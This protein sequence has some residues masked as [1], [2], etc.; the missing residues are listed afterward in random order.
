MILLSR[1]LRLAGVSLL[2]AL[3]LQSCKTAVPEL[4]DTEGSPLSQS[5]PA[6]YRLAVAPFKL[7]PGVEAALRVTGVRGSAVELQADLVSALVEMHTASEVVPIDSPDAFSAYNVDADLLLQ[8]RL[9]EA[10]FG[11]DGLT[12]RAFVSGLLWLTTWCGSLWVEDSRYRAS[13][14]VDYDLL[15]PHTGRVLA[16]DQSARSQQTDLSF[17]ERNE[18]F[19]PGFFLS[20]LVPPFLV[21]DNRRHL[22]DSLAARANSLVAAQFKTFLLNEL[23]ARQAQLLARMELLVPSNGSHTT[24]PVS[25]EWEVTAKGGLTEAAVLVNDEVYRTWKTEELEALAAE[26]GGVRIGVPDIPMPKAGRNL[27]RF[28]VNVDGLWA[29]RSVLVFNDR[30]DD[31]KPSEDERKIA[32]NGAATLT[33]DDA[34]Q[35]QKGEGHDAD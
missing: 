2:A 12:G 30:E 18:A 16:R 11:R 20:L 26:D 8:P 17:W 6:T 27:V 5:E 19:S 7:P 33:L 32:P 1:P 4:L 21:G 28:L 25:F 35:A 13:L 34:P 3:F 23:P 31:S 22:G 9:K 10:R 15:D 14:V 29:S 24:E